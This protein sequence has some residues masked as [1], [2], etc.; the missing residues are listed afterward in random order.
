MRAVVY[1]KTGD[2]SVLHVGDIP[3]PTVGPSDA[4]VKIDYAGLLHPSTFTNLQAATEARV[5][6]SNLG[7]NAFAQASTLSTFISELACTQPRSQQSPAGKG[8]AS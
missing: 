6:L 5:R 1:D 8:L 3:K 4:L 2:S 7:V